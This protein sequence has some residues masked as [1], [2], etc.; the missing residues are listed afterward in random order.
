MD[1]RVSD[2]PKLRKAAQSSESRAAER[3]KRF[4]APDHRSHIGK[5]KESQVSLPSSPV[6]KVRMPAINSGKTQEKTK[7]ATRR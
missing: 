2:P 1:G 3:Q 7:K 6:A 5:A 4:A